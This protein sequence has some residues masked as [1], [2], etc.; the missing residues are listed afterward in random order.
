VASRDL[1]VDDAANVDARGTDEISASSI[2][3]LACGRAGLASGDEL[4]EI[5]ADR[6]ESSGSSPGKY[7]DAEAAADVEHL[8]GRRR[9]AREPSARARASSPALR[10]SIPP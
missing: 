4:P 3:S 1:A 6:C 2:T 7:G 8:H 10:R 9:R 5:R